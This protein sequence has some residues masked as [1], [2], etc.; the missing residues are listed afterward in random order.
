MM[1]LIKYNRLI[2]L[3]SNILKFICNFFLILKLKKDQ[4]MES[5]QKLAYNSW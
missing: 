3:F 2:T 1:K 4:E 5:Y